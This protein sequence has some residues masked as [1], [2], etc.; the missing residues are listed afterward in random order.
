MEKNMTRGQPGS[1]LL[2]TYQETAHLLGVTKGDVRQMVDDGQLREVRV[3]SKPRISARSI[4]HTLGYDLFGSTSVPRAYS[5]LT[6][7]QYAV[8]LLNRGVRRAHS[9]TTEN[10]RYALSL[11]ADELGHIRIAD[12]REDDLRRAFRRLESRYATGSLRLA[13]TV[14]RCILRTAYENG[15]IPADPTRRWEA[16][17]STK[18]R[19]DDD[20]RVYSAEEIETIFR[21]SRAYDAEL[22]TMFTVLECTG[23]RPGELLG[24]EWSSYDDAARTLHIYQT[25]T[26]RFGTIRE[27]SKA[28][29]S[30]SVLSVPKSSYS[31]RTLRLSDRA[32]E[33]LDAWRGTLRGD[34][35][36]ARADSRFI[37]PGRLGGFRSLS[38][39]EKKLQQYR[40]A[41]GVRG[42]T[43]YK[44]RH[45]MCT[46]L[47]LE[48]Y[49]ISLIQRIMGDNSPD[50][51]AR[52]YT[53]ISADDAL[54]AMDSFFA[55]HYSAD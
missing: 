6:L 14:T 51:I 54:R 52:V 29:K 41:Q 8:R 4:G 50:V 3:G 40:T 17:K 30:E 48:K 19:R 43:F 12:I 36:R 5:E 2:L 28:A 32:V 7:S 9:R 22:Y 27:L 11:L 44:F 18:P 35:N 16:P 38:G 34:T 37:F 33:A 26:R 47:T 21:T 31:V 25:V 13:H 15:D 45:T 46:R 1:S 49:P 42:V 23:M 24:L 20:E 10:Y 55:S 39:A 53:H